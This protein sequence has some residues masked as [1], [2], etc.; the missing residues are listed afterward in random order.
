MVFRAYLTFDYEDVDEYRVHVVQNH[1][2]S[3]DIQKASHFAKTNWEASRK[4]DQAELKR[5]INAELQGTFA[6][7]VLSGERTHARRWVRYEIFKSVE[8]GNAL[9]GL[10]IHNIPAKNKRK[11][12]SGP[13]PLD[14][15]GLLISDDGCRATPTEWDS[16]KWVMFRDVD[17]F[18]ISEQPAEFRNKNLQLSHWYKS[19]D[20]VDDDGPHNIYSWIT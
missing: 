3:G 7:I 8:Q 10:K 18:P 5:L 16:T 1:K 2:F 15:V 20:W 17:E 12:A 9:L 13:N 4:L 14:Y 11:A 19:Y 6:T